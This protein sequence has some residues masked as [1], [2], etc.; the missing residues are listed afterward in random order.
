MW[1]ADYKT[2]QKWEREE[3]VA[4]VRWTCSWTGCV[5]SET[6]MESR[7]VPLRRGLC[8]SPLI[9][10]VITVTPHMRRAGVRSSKQLTRVT[11]PLDHH[12]CGFPEDNWK[13]Q[14]FQLVPLFMT[15]SWGGGRHGLLQ[16]F[17]IL[18]AGYRPVYPTKRW[19]DLP[20]VLFF[21]SRSL[22]LY[23]SV[24]PHLSLCIWLAE[25]FISVFL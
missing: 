7:D 12:V 23:P 24:I 3:T 17:N 13:P 2:R 8:V 18:L 9:S 15:W 14:I 21:L 6:R 4:S 22:P 11:R 10:A 20:V 16:Y 19:Y 1:T 5:S 25:K